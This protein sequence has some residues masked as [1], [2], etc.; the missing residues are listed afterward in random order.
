MCKGQSKQGTILHQRACRLTIAPLHLAKLRL[1]AVLLTSRHLLCVSLRFGAAFL[2]R[3][4]RYSPN[5]P[6]LFC[7]GE[8]CCC[9][10]RR[11]S[12]PSRCCMAEAITSLCCFSSYQRFGRKGFR[13]R[14]PPRMTQRE[15]R[16]FVW[17]H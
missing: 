12:E 3:M 7:R 8:D 5:I 4:R 16:I 10:R 13:S 1:T 9:G 2:T 15:R 14:K 6:T 11:S 17:G